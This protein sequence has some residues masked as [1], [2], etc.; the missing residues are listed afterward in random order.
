[1]SVANSVTDK[2]KAVAGVLASKLQLTSSTEIV[3]LITSSFQHIIGYRDDAWLK[4]LR[5]SVPISIPFIDPESFITSSVLHIKSTTLAFA[6]QQ[7]ERLASGLRAGYVPDLKLRP[8]GRVELVC[9]SSGKHWVSLHESDLKEA[10]DRFLPD[11]P[12]VLEPSNY[13]T[14]AYIILM[15]PE[16][17]Q[18]ES[19]T[20]LYQEPV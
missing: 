2:L 20:P 6:S 4:A 13:P 12:L 3:E 1:M 7:M 10:E 17:A 8:T 15:E 19:G 16:S 14:G 9:D 18:S 5:L 11:E